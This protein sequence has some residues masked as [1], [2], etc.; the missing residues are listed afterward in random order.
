[1]GIYII[2]YDLRKPG[3][4]YDDL[5]TSIKSYN[6]IHPLESCWLISTALNYKQ[7]SNHLASK[8]DTN[9]KLSVMKV[10]DNINTEWY[11]WNFSRNE[12]EWLQN[13]L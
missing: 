13:N 11:T 10:A 1:M 7:I 12:A 5:Y 3:R 2:N 8:I 9:D 6:H 4:N